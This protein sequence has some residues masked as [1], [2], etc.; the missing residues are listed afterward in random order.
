MSKLFLLTQEENSGY[1]T[2]DSVVVCAETADDALIMRPGGEKSF[3]TAVFT[4][5]SWATKAEN[6]TVKYLGEAEPDIEVNSVVCSSFNA[7]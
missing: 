7:G 4:C 1:G 6:V 5:G 2:F 3:E